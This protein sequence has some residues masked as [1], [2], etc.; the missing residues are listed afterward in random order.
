ME[1]LATKAEELHNKGHALRSAEYFGRAAEAARA[2]GPDNLVTIYLHLRQGKLLSEFTLD[3]VHTADPSQCAANRAKLVA[4]LS[5]AVEALERG[6]VAGTLLEG[7]CTAAEEAWSG[8]YLQRDVSNRVLAAVAARATGYEQ[9]LRAANVFWRVLEW[10]FASQDECS[11]AQFRLFVQHAVHAAELM[12][13]P[14]YGD[15]AMFCE[16]DFTAGLRRTVSVAPLSLRLG[17]VSARP[18][19]VDFR[20]VQLLA[21]ALQRLERSGVLQARGIE[22]HIGSDAEEQQAFL[23]LVRKR[24][25]AT[26]RFTCA[27][28]GYGAEEAHRAHF[29]RCAACQTVVYCCREHQVEGGQATSGRAKQRCARLLLR[30]GRGQAAREAFCRSSRCAPAVRHRRRRCCPSSSCGLCFVLCSLCFPL[31]VSDPA[32]TTDT[33]GCAGS[34]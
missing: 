20:L 12:Q 11:D 17:A 8:G 33:H 14:R 15:I 27:L 10:S 16:V 4:L 24:Q 18:P 30:T 3:T 21:G 5:G 19:P 31:R 2:L 26:G 25:A 32:A 9:F 29:K 7:K 22:E 1:A 6:R 34:C 23:A 28:A 13:L